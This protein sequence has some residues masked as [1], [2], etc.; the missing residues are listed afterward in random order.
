MN[1]SNSEL[2][3]SYSVNQA[4]ERP[5]LN[6]KPRSQPLEPLEGNTE[7]K[8]LAISSVAICMLKFYDLRLI[9]KVSFS[10]S[11]VH[12]FVFHVC[13]RSRVHSFNA[14]KQLMGSYH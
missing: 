8:R 2:S 14:A 6:L 9:L 12:L 4:V 13:S 11:V 7:T 10:L 5:K 3:G 1:P